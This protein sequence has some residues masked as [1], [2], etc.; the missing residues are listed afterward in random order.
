M[1]TVLRWKD[2]RFFFWSGDRGESPHIHVKRGAG[3]AKIWL[4]PIRLQK[5]VDFKNHEIREIVR[6]GSNKRLS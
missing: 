6:C 5:T 2:Y 3:E 4:D 1:P